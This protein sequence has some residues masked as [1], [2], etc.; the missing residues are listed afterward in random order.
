ISPAQMDWPKAGLADSTAV[1]KVVL[2]TAPISDITGQE[3]SD[4]FMDIGAGDRWEGFPA[5]RDEILDHIADEGLTGVVWLS[6]DLHFGAAMSVEPEGPRAVM[7]E[8]LVGP[9]GRGGNH[10]L[11][12]LFEVAPPF[13]F[14]T[15]LDNWVRFEVDPGT[16]TTRLAFVGADGEEFYSEE[17]R[18]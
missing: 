15:D 11:V 17:I 14:F 1:F 7:N 13:R 9:A 4:G 8:I 12:P 18:A 16:R 6:G 5:Q 3:A 10:P 2:N